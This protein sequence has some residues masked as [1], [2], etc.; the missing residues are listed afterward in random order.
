MRV[1]RSCRCRRSGRR[2]DGG[3]D[4]ALGLGDHDRAAA[5]AGEPVPLAG[6]VALEAVGLVPGSGPGQALA[7]IEPKLRD[8]LLVGGPVV[9]AV[10]T[11]VPA[12]H[13]GKQPFES[14][15][16]TTAAFPVNQSAWS[17]IPSF[18]DPELVGLFFRTAKL[19]GC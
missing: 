6:M 16:V 9:G 14:G 18:L 2:G 11:R 3:V 17:T 12:L 5:E 19:A 7:D 13:A 1:R 10:E 4:H 8:R 15:R